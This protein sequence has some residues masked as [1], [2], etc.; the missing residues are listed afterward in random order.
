VEV[1]DVT[2]RIWEIQVFTVD[3]TSFKKASSERGRER[4]S[5]SLPFQESEAADMRG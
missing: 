2:V 3:C 5:K 4:L 1:R